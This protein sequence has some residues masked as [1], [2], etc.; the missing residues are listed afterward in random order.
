M[1]TIE[2]IKISNNADNKNNII[3][4]LSQIGVCLKSLKVNDVYSCIKSNLNNFRETEQELWLQKY[5]MTEDMTIEEIEA[6]DDIEQMR[7]EARQ[8]SLS[9]GNGYQ[10]TP[11]KLLSYSQYSNTEI[12]AISDLY[13][14]QDDILIFIRED[15]EGN[16]NIF[17]VKLE[18]N[19]SDELYLRRL[20]IDLEFNIYNEDTYHYDKFSQVLRE[21]LVDLK[22]EDTFKHT[23]E[24]MKV[25]S[26]VGSDLHDLFMKLKELKNND[27]DLLNKSFKNYFLTPFIIIGGFICYIYYLVNFDLI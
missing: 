17:F 9:N 19:T 12:E 24:E 16:S 14:N 6:V 3:T 18:Y 2:I 11:Y 15:D 7:E 4:L 25:I 20:Y 21:C 10:S 27:E 22:N 8:L 5:N 26:Q 23:E 1:N 13:N